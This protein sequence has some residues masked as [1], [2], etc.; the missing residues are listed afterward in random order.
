MSKTI[1]ITAKVAGDVV[2]YE[3]VLTDHWDF[4]EFDAELDAAFGDRLYSLLRIEFEEDRKEAEA[5][6][7]R[8]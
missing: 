3:Y 6:K 5:W 8:R 2:M 1:E 7:H 4:A